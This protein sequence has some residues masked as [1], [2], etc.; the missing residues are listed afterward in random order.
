MRKT[1]TI[2]LT[3][4]LTFSAAFAAANL[5]P[6][7]AL[8]ATCVR[9]VVPAAYAT[10]KTC[11]DWYQIAAEDKSAG[12]VWGAHQAGYTATEYKAVTTPLE[13]QTAIYQNE[14]VSTCQLAISVRFKW[15]G[16]PGAVGP[17]LTNVIVETIPELFDSGANPPTKGNN[18]SITLD[19]KTKGLGWTIAFVETSTMT[20]RNG[21]GKLTE[22]WDYNSADAQTLARIAGKSK[23]A[24]AVSDIQMYQDPTSNSYA[25][26]TSTV[27]FREAHNRTNKQGSALTALPSIWYASEGQ[28]VWTAKRSSACSGTGVIVAARYFRTEQAVREACEY[29]VNVFDT[30]AKGIFSMIPIAGTGGR[31]AEIVLGQLTSVSARANTCLDKS[32]EKITPP[33]APILFP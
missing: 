30:L 8:G 18:D 22:T 5:A 31:L 3:V 2:V 25:H 1:L 24:I 7:K 6:D 20:G 23:G 15:N 28:F 16:V 33:S 9:G 11:S 13:L 19:F 17:S 10:Q 21:M 32:A 4:G 27:Q 12:S 26:Y 14:S 29:K